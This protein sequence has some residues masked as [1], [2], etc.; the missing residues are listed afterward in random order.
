MCVAIGRFDMV[1][2]KECSLQRSDV[3]MTHLLPHIDLR[4]SSSLLALS[5]I[6]LSTA[7]V[8]ARNII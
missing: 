6:A 8:L 1:K 5:N 3:M 2:E 7:L 4:T